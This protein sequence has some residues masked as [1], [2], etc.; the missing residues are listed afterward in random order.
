MGGGHFDNRADEE[1]LQEEEGKQQKKIFQLKEVN[2]KVR[3]G[4][5]ETRITHAPTLIT[6][7]D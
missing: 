3:L 2:Y 7:V 6:A 5:L 1:R 4:L